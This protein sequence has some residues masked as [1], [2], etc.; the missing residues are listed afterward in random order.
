MKS[1]DKILREASDD[2]AHVLAK[3]PPVDDVDAENL[4]VA[5]LPDAI[6]SKWFRT[7]DVVACFADLKNSTQ[8]SVG[9]HPRSTAAIYRAASGNA[10]RVMHD[11]DADFIQIQGDGVF[12]LFWGDAAVERAVCAGVTVKTFS[13]KHLEPALSSKWPDA[14]IT[15]FKV[16]VATGRVLVKNIGTPRNP[17]EQEPVWAGK[18]VNYAAKAAQQADRGELIVSGSVWLAIEANDYLTTSCGHGVDGGTAPQPSTLWRDV[19]IEKLGHD[20][21]EAAGRLLTACWCDLC[22]PEF[23]AAILNGET[24]RPE[25]NQARQ[26]AVA[27]R[28]A[29]RA[30]RWQRMRR[31]RA[32][33]LAGLRQVR[34]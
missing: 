9:K 26:A 5:D 13:E 12:G 14:P 34:R 10:T 31:D 18:P 4:D 8:L 32:A 27:T 16:G 24:V 33:R 22:G 7:D 6:G 1:L 17:A 19:T 30:A 29:T 3:N 25:A 21:D 23:V 2:T 15:G 28:D 20:D 11:F